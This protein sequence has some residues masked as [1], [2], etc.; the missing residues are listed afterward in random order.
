MSM[1]YNKLKPQKREEDR[2]YPEQDKVLRPRACTDWNCN[3]KQPLPS[4]QC[5]Q[6]HVKYKESSLEVTGS[7]RGKQNKE[8]EE[9]RWGGRKKGREEGKITVPNRNI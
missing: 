2:D 1:W 7:I 5:L 4:M 9:R 6:V 3:I 8:E